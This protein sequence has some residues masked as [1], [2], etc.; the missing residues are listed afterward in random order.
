MQKS[1]NNF[2]MVSDRTKVSG[3]ANLKIRIFALCQE[4]LVPVYF[5]RND[6]F[7]HDFLIG[8]DM[9]T[10]FKFCQR[11]D[12][13]SKHTDNVRDNEI[14][15]NF[16]KNNNFNVNFNKFIKSRNFDSNLDH[17][18]DNKKYMISNLINKLVFQN[19]KLELL[20]LQ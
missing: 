12:L 2:N 20:I 11:K 4:V 13:L 5:V 7:C 15:N 16:W 9:I 14:N 1:E 17:L 10:Q 8:L 18:D 3:E 6:S 19:Q